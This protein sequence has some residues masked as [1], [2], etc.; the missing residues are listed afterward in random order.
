MANEI[1]KLQDAINHAQKIVFFGGAGVSTESGIP[2]FRSAEGLF[3]QDTGLTYH[4]ED[5]VSSW[6]LKENPEGFFDY[7]FSNL[8]YPE[9]KPNPAHLFL[10]DLEKYGKDISIVTQNID[11]LHQE[12]GSRKVYELHGSRYRNHCLTCGLQIAYEN[13]EKDGKGIPRC[14]HDGGIVRPDIVLYGEML[15]QN[16][17]TESINAISEADTMIIAGTSLS[18]YPANGLVHYF[19]GKQLIL[20]NKTSVSAARQVDILIE[21]AVGKVFSQLSVHEFKG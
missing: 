13:L 15:D 21:D 9:A 6:F 17:M 5:L 10:A 11:G 16:T 3:Q 19:S 20:I 4:P 1:R 8:V 2:D 7:Y 12:A 18:V 14:P